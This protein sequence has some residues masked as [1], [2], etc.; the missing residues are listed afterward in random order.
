M[1]TFQE[2]INNIYGCEIDLCDLSD[3]DEELL[4]NEYIEEVQ[5]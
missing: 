1:I 2:Y 3:E 4:Y 5:K